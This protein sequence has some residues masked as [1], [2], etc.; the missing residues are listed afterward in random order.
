[1]FLILE[2]FLFKIFYEQEITIVSKLFIRKQS[3][4]LGSIDSRFKF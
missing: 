4:Y 1:M 2:V 3:A